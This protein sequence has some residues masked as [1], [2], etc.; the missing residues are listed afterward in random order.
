M[1]LKAGEA[2]ERCVENM[3]RG[4]EI[5]EGNG[6]GRLKLFLC[7]KKSINTRLTFNA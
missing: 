4:P 1:W 2:G 6:Y 7:K 5:K 3:K